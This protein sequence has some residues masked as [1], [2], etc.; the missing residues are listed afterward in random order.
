MDKS[1]S[2]S[3]G[4]QKSVV[5][6][7]KLKNFLKVDSPTSFYLHTSINFPVF[8]KILTNESPRYI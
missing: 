7:Q 2:F 5:I 6:G 3:V 1:Q 8:P 4:T